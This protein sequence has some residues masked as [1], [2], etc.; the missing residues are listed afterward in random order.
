M[1]AM[2]TFANKVKAV[3]NA[4]R[5]RRA[6]QIQAVYEDRRRRPQRLT[7]IRYPA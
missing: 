6:E 4:R 7:P 5:T 2:R 1:D 3:R